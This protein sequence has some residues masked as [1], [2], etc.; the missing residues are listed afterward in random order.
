MLALISREG[1]DIRVANLGGSL[2]AAAYFAEAISYSLG[3]VTRVRPATAPPPPPPSRARACTSVEGGVCLW[4][5]HAERTP[6]LYPGRRASC[7]P[8]ELLPLQVQS[9]PCEHSHSC[10]RRRS[11]RAACRLPRRGGDRAVCLQLAAFSA[12]P[13]E[14][15]I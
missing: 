2:G 1:F 8:P 11:P 4:K 14:P 6:A 12:P 10:R 7:S 5:S 13:F 15:G 3:Y 9:E